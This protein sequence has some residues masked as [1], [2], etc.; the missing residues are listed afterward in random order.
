VRV[1]SR[2]DYPGKQ[3]AASLTKQTGD[4]ARFC[5][6]RPDSTPPTATTCRIVQQISAVMCAAEQRFRG[7]QLTLVFFDLAIRIVINAAS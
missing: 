2:T 4:E 3:R 7:D 1:L 6:R 5:R